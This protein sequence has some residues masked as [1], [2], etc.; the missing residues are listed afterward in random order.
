MPRLYTSGNWLVKEGRESDFVSAWRDL[1]E[2]TAA[3][4]PGA[5]PATLLRDLDEPRRFLSFG[6]WQ[7]MGSIEAW[8]GSEGFQERLGRI[9]ELLDEAQPRT[10]EVAAEVT[11]G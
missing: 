10:L 7:D 4:V 2:W 3:N 8:R 5:G 9:R 11:P 6:P 1:A